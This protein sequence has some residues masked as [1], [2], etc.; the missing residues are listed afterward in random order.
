MNALQDLLVDL[1]ALAQQAKQLHWHVQ[2]RDFRSIHLQIDEVVASAR[3][4]MD[5]VAERSVTLGYA[6]D[7]TPETVAKEH[8][9]PPLP[10]A[11]VQDEDAVRL[12]ADAIEKVTTRGRAVIEATEDEPVTQDL[13]I[14][15]VGGLEKH[16]WMLRAQLV[17]R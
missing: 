15:V 7:G 3:Q 12:L 11:W 4:Y 5:D 17:K 14:E 1:S 13:A 10:E 6:V 9:L 8:D 2:G 16:L